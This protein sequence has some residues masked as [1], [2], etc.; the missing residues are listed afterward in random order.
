MNEFEEWKKGLEK[1]VVA[2]KF[3]KV[4]SAWLSLPQNEKGERI[5]PPK[6]R[7]EMLELRIWIAKLEIPLDELENFQ[8]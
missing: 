1:E 3:R 6:L 4:Y 5:V 7:D 2:E 8:D